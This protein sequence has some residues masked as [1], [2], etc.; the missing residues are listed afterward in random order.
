MLLLC[1]LCSVAFAVRTYNASIPLNND[2]AV[3][4]WTVNS[5]VL[6]IAIS[7]RSL[8]WVAVGFSPVSENAMIANGGGSDITMGFVNAACPQGCLA[9]YAPSAYPS[10]SGNPSPVT[11]VSTLVN[12]SLSGGIMTLEF[13]RPLASTIINPAVPTTVLQS[14]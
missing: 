4:Q 12:V 6:Q 2:G 3:L 5:T 9:N 14:P 7:A 13:D 10:D 1:V 8:G 11:T